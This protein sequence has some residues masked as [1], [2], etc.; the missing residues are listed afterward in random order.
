MRRSLV[1]LGGVSLI[2]LL[3]TIYLFALLYQSRRAMAESV[4]ED[5]MWAAYQTDRQAGAMG[6]AIDHVLLSGDPAKLPTVARA[7][8]LLY[9]RATL[10]EEG[11]F[12]I[13]FDTTPELAGQ[14]ARVLSFVQD[15][16]SLSVADVAFSLATTRA[17]FE[18]RAVVTG[19]DRAALLDGIVDSWLDPAA[20]MAE[21]MGVPPGDA[22][23]FARLGVAVTRG[24]LLDLLATKDR[25]GVD[26]SVTAEDRERNE[27]RKRDEGKPREGVEPAEPGRR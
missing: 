6:A 20:E 8:D 1:V 22:R 19:A 3:S 16:P 7:Y 11:S 27:A 18:R 12:A 10:I 15:R 23:A 24:L 17:S 14:A 21:A 26:A 9:S 4:R 5:A 13:K 25:A 2:L